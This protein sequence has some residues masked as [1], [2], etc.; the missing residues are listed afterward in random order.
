MPAQW[1][2]LLMAAAAFVGQPILAA[3]GFRP[4][5]GHEGS[6]MTQEPPER[7]LRARLPGKIARPTSIFE[8]GLALCIRARSPNF[9]SSFIVQRRQHKTNGRR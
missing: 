3:A 6:L 4:S 1:H 9:F 2:K 8:E 7:R 5:A